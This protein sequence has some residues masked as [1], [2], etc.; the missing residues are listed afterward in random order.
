MSGGGAR[1]TLSSHDCLLPSQTLGVRPA[2]GPATK[3]RAGAPELASTT[4]LLPSQGRY[5]GNREVIHQ[6]KTGKIKWVWLLFDDNQMYTKQGIWHQGPLFNG[7]L[8]GGISGYPG[9]LLNSGGQIQ[10]SLPWTPVRCATIS[11]Q[12]E[13]R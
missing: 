7:G 11:G 12:M 3:R 6:G 8:K 4:L 9:V 13:R 10:R 1:L 2:E 5:A